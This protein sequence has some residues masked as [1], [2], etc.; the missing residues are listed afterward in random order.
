VIEVEGASIYLKGDETVDE[1]AT[2]AVLTI[3]IA[4]IPT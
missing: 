1:S 4:C 2:A 3:E